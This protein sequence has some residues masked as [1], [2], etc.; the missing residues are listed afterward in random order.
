M[1]KIKLV[2]DS[3]IQLTPEEVA[4]YDIRVVPLTIMIDSTVYID[5]ETITRSEFMEK[6]WLKPKP[7]LKRLNQRPAHF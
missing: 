4:R 7:Y 3:S 6:K 2:T 1:A 5:G